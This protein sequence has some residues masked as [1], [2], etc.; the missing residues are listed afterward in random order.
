MPRIQDTESQKQRTEEGVLFN[1]LIGFPLFRLL[2]SFYLAS[3]ALSAQSALSA[4]SALSASSE[5]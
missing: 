5:H 1:G 4:L 3:S 2:S